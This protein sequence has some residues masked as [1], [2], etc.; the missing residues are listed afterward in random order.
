M[1][2][3]KTNPAPV[4]AAAAQGNHNS[5]GYKLHNNSYQSNSIDEW[6]VRDW[7][8]P[9]F[10]PYDLWIQMQAETQFKTKPIIDR[11]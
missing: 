1:H 4:S 10:H 7:R 6:S 2:A 9:N 8:L 3:T 11:S 5:L